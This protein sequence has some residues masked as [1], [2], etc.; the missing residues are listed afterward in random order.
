MSQ[1]W[2][3]M[4]KIKVEGFDSKGFSTEIEQAN[5]EFK[6][7]DNQETL[8]GYDA[9]AYTEIHEENQDSS[10]LSDLYSSSDK[11]ISL[12][13]VHKKNIIIAIAI[14]LLIIL[15]IVYHFAYDYIQ[16]LL[17][18]EELNTPN[19]VVQQ[20]KETPIYA[21]SEAIGLITPD[22]SVDVVSRA[23][24]YLQSTMF[25]EGD[26]VQKGQ[27]LFKIEPNELQIAVRSAQASVAQAKALYVNSLQELNRANELIKENF[28]SRSDY[29]GIVAQSNSSKATLDAAEQELARAKLNLSYSNIYS[30]L[31]GKAG[32]IALSNGN[33]VG[34]Q[35]VLVNI[36]KTSPICVSF[37]IKSADVIRLKTDNDGKFDLSTAK[38][39]LILADNTKYPYT[40]KINFSDN[41][42]ASD[43]A[44]LSLKAVFDN[45]NNILVPG[46]YVKVIVTATTPSNHILLPHAVVSGDA[47]NGYYVWCVV[48]GKTVKKNIKVL[49]SQLNDWII[50]SGVSESDYIIVEADSN[51][52][53]D[54]MKVIVKDK[55]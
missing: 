22:A 23:S 17:Y 50:E 20:Y 7:E 3:D 5:K 6:S 43:A 33:F 18:K 34:L 12:F 53:M 47:I 10:G 44:T 35:T 24:G 29:D 36:A 32:K 13:S 30:P 28:I 4:P 8:G 11:K 31:T 1:D 45:P 38:V 16:V 54:D 25:K 40:G 9:S 51:I 21:T 27:L 37:S 2:G 46:D 26:F 55:L 42:I 49:S 52:D 19:V 48:D 39:E 14:L 41:M 15:P